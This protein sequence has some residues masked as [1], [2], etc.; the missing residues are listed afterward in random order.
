MSFLTIVQNACD[1]LSIER[2]TA[3][4]SSTDE[5]IRTLFG[6]AQQ[7]GRELARRATWTALQ[8]EQT[9]TATATELQTG[10]IPSDFD[11]MI[12]ST[13]FDRT[14][15]ERVFGPL[16]QAE[17]QNVKATL[18]VRVDPCF[19]IIAG[20]LYINPAPTAGHTFAFEYM[21]KNWCQSSGGTGQTAWAADTDT[22]KIDEE[23]HILGVVWR[24]KKSKG[25]EYGEDFASYERNVAQA[26]QRDGPKPFIYTGDGGRY[27]M[28][29]APQVPDTLVF[30]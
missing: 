16:T 17:W 6:L 24:F 2:P 23:L 20:N 5:N 13:M 21:S 14:E 27:R 1:R 8:A 15:R 25:L 30:S 19:R 10:A 22:A 29:I 12:P 7:E 9:F 11:Y 18:V 26:V 3:V 4:F 28:P